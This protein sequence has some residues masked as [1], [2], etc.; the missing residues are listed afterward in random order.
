MKERER[1]VEAAASEAQHAELVERINQ[2]TILR[3]SNATLRAECDS[4]GKR[5]KALE[6][7]L[8][9]LSSELDPAKEQL[10]LARAELEA[11]DQ[12]VKQ[13]EEETRRWQERNASLLSKV[14]CE[15]Y[16]SCVPI[17]ITT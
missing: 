12:Q 1:A 17:F 15:P 8:Q 3:E 2:L 4:H 7:K 6:T 14:S 13:L 16:Y 11:R 5:A 10:R 9:Q